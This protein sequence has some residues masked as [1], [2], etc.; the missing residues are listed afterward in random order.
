MHDSSV[1]AASVRADKKRTKG[2]AIALDVSRRRAMI[3]VESNRIFTSEKY[4]PMPIFALK[5]PV[6]AQLRAAL[7][8]L[9]FQAAGTLFLRELAEVVH[10]VELQSTQEEN[11]A[12]I[13][14][15][16]NLGVFA[17]ALVDPDIREY[18]RPSILQAHWRERIGILMPQRRD[19]WW[20]IESAGQAAAVGAEI[21]VSVEEYGLPPLAK[22]ADLAA[23]RRIWE[24]GA[25][26]GLSD[27]QRRR[28]LERL[29]ASSQD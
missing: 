23:L 20:S 7:E 14:V 17:P 15:T 13:A 27:Y 25:S 5:A 10:L 12:H 29:A 16:I 8:P 9:G 22:I 28:H 26:P 19:N 11:A 4:S 24:T 6:L 3:F 2:E 18:I 1:T 21:A